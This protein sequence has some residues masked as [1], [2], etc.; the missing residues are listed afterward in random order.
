MWN[1]LYWCSEW[2]Q[3]ALCG[4]KSVN[5]NTESVKKFGADFSHNKNLEQ[6]K[7]FCEHITK[8]E[9]ILKLWCMRQ[10]TLGWTITVFKSLAVSKVMHLLLIT[11]LHDN[12]IDLLYKIQKN[13]IWQGKKAKKGVIKNIDLRNKITIQCPW[14]KRMFGDD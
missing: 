2:G 4:T 8:I 10:L 1:Y 7:V 9:N 5:L 11:K 13:F 3:V 6:D 14:V 12:T